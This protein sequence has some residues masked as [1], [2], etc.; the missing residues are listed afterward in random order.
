[1]HNAKR[2]VTVFW[3]VY[4]NKGGKENFVMCFFSKKTGIVK[5]I[6]MEIDKN[7][8]FLLTDM[9]EVLG[10]GFEKL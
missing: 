10:E 6:V 7:A 8:F 3:Y 5:N 9:K 4:V 1:M 2:G